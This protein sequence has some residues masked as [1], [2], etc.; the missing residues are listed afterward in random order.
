MEDVEI[1]FDVSEL[2]EFKDQFPLEEL[3]EKIIGEILHNTVDVAKE[4]LMFDGLLSKYV[5]YSKPYRLEIND[6]EKEFLYDYETKSLILS[7]KVKDKD[8]LNTPKLIQHKKCWIIVDVI[9][10]GINIHLC[11]DL[12]EYCR[13][14]SK[15]FSGEYNYAYLCTLDHNLEIIDW[16]NFW[17]GHD[18]ENTELIEKARK[19]V[20]KKYKKQFV[21]TYGELYTYM[22]N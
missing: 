16:H 20:L 22:E 2:G 11:N 7:I 14:Y 1:I 17:D 5:H 19:L 18:K 15:L 13:T 9:F 4:K 6:Y 8:G 10:G 3:S 21:K 12:E